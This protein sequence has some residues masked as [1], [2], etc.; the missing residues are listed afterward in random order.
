MDQDFGPADGHPDEIGPGRWRRDLL[1]RGSRR[2]RCSWRRTLSV[3]PSRQKRWGIT[4]LV[5]AAIIFSIYELAD[6]S[7]RFDA[8]KAGSDLI[9]TSYGSGLTL[10]GLGLIISIA[11]SNRMPS[12]SA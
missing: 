3:G 8:A 2:Q 6:I 4:A 1:P 12:R 9:V 10:I 5:L 11:G 7:N